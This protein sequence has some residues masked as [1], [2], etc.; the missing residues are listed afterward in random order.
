MS[1]EIEAP[2]K[3]P[4]SR[5]RENNTLRFGL[6]WGL[7]GASQLPVPRRVVTI[8]LRNTRNPPRV[9]PGR[10]PVSSRQI[11]S[12]FPVAMGY[13]PGHFPVYSRSP[14][15]IPVRLPFTSLSL[16]ESSLS[17]LDILIV[18]LK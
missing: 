16:T 3:F 6:W 1:N 2:V 12:R 10:F 17:H 7:A 9:P 15:C 14:W 11:P 5:R 8:Q 4:F 13:Y 18:A